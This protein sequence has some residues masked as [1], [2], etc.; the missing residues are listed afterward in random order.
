MLQREVAAR[1]LAQPGT[2][3]YGALSVFFQYYA[4]IHHCFEVSRQAFSPVPA[5]DSTVLSFTP[6]PAPPWPSVNEDFFLNI[7]KYAFMHRRKTLRTNLFA[8]AHLGLT[9]AQL[10]ETFST[11]YLAENVRPQ[12][13]H[14]SQ[15]VQLADALYGL[16]TTGKTTGRHQL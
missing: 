15:F 1:L 3:T 5:V 14:V 6:F 10:T 2:S 8:A 9:K 7:V 4:E 16:P 12:E 13:L 11:L